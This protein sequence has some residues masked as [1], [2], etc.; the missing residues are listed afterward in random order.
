MRAVPLLLLALAGCPGDDEGNAP[1]LWLAPDGSEIRVKLA[2]Q[3]P[4]PF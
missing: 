2:D 3:R 1:T 4:A